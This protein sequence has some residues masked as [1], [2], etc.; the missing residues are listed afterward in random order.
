MSSTFSLPE[1]RSRDYL[2]NLLNP[3]GTC[4]I[5][6][7]AKAKI[8]HKAFRASDDE[9]TFSNIQGT[10]VFGEDIAPAGDRVRNTKLGHDLLEPYW[11][12]LVDS[13]TSKVVWMSRVPDIFAYKKDRPFFHI[14]SGSVC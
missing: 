1:V 3:D 9:W 4:E 11:F 14:F 5:I 12:R 13:K 6:A 10:L 8:Y 2:S 7:A